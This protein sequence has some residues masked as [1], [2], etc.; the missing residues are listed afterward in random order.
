MQSA[1]QLLSELKKL[2]VKL[3]LASGKL[4]C[5]APKGVMT[6]TLREEIKYHK[7]KLLHILEKRKNTLANGM[8]KT[9]P[10]IARDGELALS[11][12]QERIWL[13][14]KL[15]PDNHNTGNIHFSFRIEGSLDVSALGKTINAIIQRH[16]V[17]RTR[18]QTI[19][20]RPVHSIVP[21][22]NFKLQVRDL[23][24]LPSQQIEKVVATA[25]EQYII[26][27]FDLAKAPILRSELLKIKEHEY[28]FLLATHLYIFDGWSTAILF[29]ELSSFYSTF[30]NNE[31]SVLAP[32]TA[33]YVDFS[34]WH[35]NWFESDEAAKQTSYW[36]QKLNNAQLVTHLAQNHR[37]PF[38]TSN[39]TANID[40]TLPSF[41]SEAIR[42]LSQK[43]ATT[44]F[45]SLQATWQTLLYCYTRQN[46]IT[47]G[48]IVSNRRVAEVENLIGSFAN[49]ILISS[50]ISAG[51]TF[52]ELVNQVGKSSLEAYAHQDI[53]FERLLGELNLALSCTPLFRV[54]FVLHQH[55]S[56]ENQGLELCGLKIQKI[57]DKKTLSKYDLE[58]IMVDRNGVLSGLFEYNAGIFDRAT[59]EK[60]KDNFFLILKKIT[61]NPELPL[62]ELSS[63]FPGGQPSITVVT[64]HTSNTEYVSPRTAIEFKIAKIWQDMFGIEKISVYDRFVDL[65]GHSLL[66]IKLVSILKDEFNVDIILVSLFEF[67]NIAELA[68]HIDKHS[69][70][71]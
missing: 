27:P 48:S 43:L 54:M 47:T 24:S 22:I 31:P 35:R 50:D 60:M 71:G 29:K 52:K 19:N 14:S 37:K 9:L 67:P 42:K 63:F 16:E 33:Q 55:Q 41:L 64:D 59:I 58:L 3:S 61:E 12:S 8:V 13:L 69:K 30:H 70:T 44:L 32:L 11:F 6:P 68:E 57:P 45:I 51:T 38:K 18:C 5:N 36:K 40:F 65:G 20:N 10:Q 4:S 62:V 15:D 25:V 49:N 2:D 23:T 17:F 1:E 66:A 46:N 7:A 53:P 34:H 26:E 21:E 39:E 28:V 56:I